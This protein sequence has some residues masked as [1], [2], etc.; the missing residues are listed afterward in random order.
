MD[1]MT[2]LFGSTTALRRWAVGSLAAN[3]ALV[4]TGAIVRLTDSGMGCP[5]WPH[6]DPG[7][8]VPR[9]AF[10]M[11]AAIEF[12]N[13]LLTFVLVILAAG[14]V[15]A[16]HRSGAVRFAKVLAW[17]ALA[18]IPLQGVI[19]GITVLTH[20]N[21]FVVAL[22]L[23]LSVALIVLLVRLV[24]HLYGLAP[25]PLDAGRHLLV[26]G[27]FVA[28]MVVNYLGTVVTGSGPNAGDHGSVRTG[29]QIEAVAR[30]HSLAVWITVAG[31]VACVVALRRLPDRRPARVAVAALA[32]EAV[33]GLIGYTQYFTH[34]PTGLVIAHMVGV[35][36]F[37]A[38][39]AALLFSV[40]RAD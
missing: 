3:M 13:R 33:Q 40:R 14:T 16:A 29:F 12:G 17:I 2:R 5:T 11:H 31:T 7:S 4:V 6:C 22:H 18:G 30:L 1:L 39:I 34:L 26:V 32:V 24:L 35:A 27:T 37:T 10:S 28:G 9:G 19:G 25:V 38:V 8:F 36:A 23:L 15:L 20:L 21:P